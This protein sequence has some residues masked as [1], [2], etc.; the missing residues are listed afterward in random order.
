MANLRQG[1]TFADTKQR[2]SELMKIKGKQFDKIKWSLL[3][4]ATYSKAEILDDGE[5]SFM[6]LQQPEFDC[7]TEDCLW[8]LVGNR[9]D[10]ALGLDHANKS[11]SF[12]GKTDS[13][14]IR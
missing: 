7:V 8:D 12:W 6:F 4:R 1:E 5:F 2:L 10:L 3:A 11:R 9:D 13:I 14:F